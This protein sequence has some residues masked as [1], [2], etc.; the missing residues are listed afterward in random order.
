MKGDYGEYKC[1]VS[2]ECW[3]RFKKEFPET[4]DYWTLRKILSTMN[5]LIIDEVIDN[6]SGFKLPYNFGH[7]IMAGTL[8]KSPKSRMKGTPLNLA[9]TE[10]YVYS[11]VWLPGV[12]YNRTFYRAKTPKLIQ[13]YIT[14]CIREDKFLNWIKVSKYSDLIKLTV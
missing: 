3:K 7:L 8:V 2:H 9:R 12:Q 11:L 14:K 6:P 4:V 1:T 13:R 10:N 5:D